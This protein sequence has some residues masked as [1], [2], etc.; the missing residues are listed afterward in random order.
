MANGGTDA[1][2]LALGVGAA[3]AIVVLAVLFVPRAGGPVPE[4]TPLAAVPVPSGPI[5]GI[6]EAAPVAEPQAVAPPM[7]TQLRVDPQGQVGVGGVAHP[8]AVVEV[9]VDGAPVARTQANEAGD[10]VVLFDLPPSDQ[11]RSLTLMEDPDGAAVLSDEA[12]LVAPFAAPESTADGPVA[13]AEGAGVPDVVADVVETPDALVVEPVAEPVAEGVAEVET[14]PAA[15]P[16]AQ[17]TVLAVD[18]EGVRVVQPATPP[19]VMSIVALDTITYDPA[20]DVAL[21][22]RASG[23]GEVRIYLDNTP[24]IATAIGPD[25]AWRTA[26]PQVDTGTYTLRVDEVDTAGTVI[27][28]IETPFLREEPAAV[29]ET[30]AAQ[31]T[32]DGFVA[33][34]TTVQPGMTLWAIARD[35]YGEG[36]LY[37]QVYEANKDAIRDPDLIYPGQVFVM[38]APV[39]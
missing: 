1:L 12:R 37:V 24:L 8:G 6:T 16:D 17:P 14:E 30:L 5:A 34:V 2:K 29:A 35:Q 15:I 18:A 10:F 13:V 11:P 9:R 25:G 38:P 31:T 19:E 28:R 39:E 4:Q 22:G 7:F 36:T 27:S 33:A 26:L 32:A 20:G 3:A 23:D 21:T